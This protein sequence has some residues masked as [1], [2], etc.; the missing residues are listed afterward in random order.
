MV[1]SELGISA[2]ERWIA[3]RLRLLDAMGHSISFV[4]AYSQTPAKT[5]PFLCAFLD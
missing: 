4:I 5:N 2:L 1:A 3:V